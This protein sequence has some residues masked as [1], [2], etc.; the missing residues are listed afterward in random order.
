G[1][2]SSGFMQRTLKSETLTINASNKDPQ[3]S[4]RWYEDE[5]RTILFSFRYEKLTNEK[6]I[7]EY[8]PFG[9][10]RVFEPHIILEINPYEIN[11]TASRVVCRIISD[12]LRPAAYGSE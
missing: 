6:G 9:L 3:K 10:Y 4:L 12:L 8:R 2:F 5:I 1:F 11:L 7:E